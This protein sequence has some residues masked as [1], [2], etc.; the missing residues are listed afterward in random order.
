MHQRVGGGLDDH[1]RG[2][3]QAGAERERHIRSTNEPPSQVQY[4]EFDS[5]WLCPAVNRVVIY[6]RDKHHRRDGCAG[7]QHF[8]KYIL[9]REKYLTINIFPSNMSM[10]LKTYLKV[11]YFPKAS[12]QL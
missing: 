9:C 12:L 2:E 7:N 8:Q 10:S 4:R 5:H 3:C 11:Q 1:R 6:V